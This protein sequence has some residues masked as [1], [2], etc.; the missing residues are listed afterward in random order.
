MNSPTYRP[1]HHVLDRMEEYVE[2]NAAGH[3]YMD[4]RKLLLDRMVKAVEQACWD[5][6]RGEITGE[7]GEILRK[8][9]DSFFY[10]LEAS[11]QQDTQET[12]CAC[13]K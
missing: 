11:H 2:R 5:E 13:A 7:E 4:Y 10:L 12:V 9:L 8:Q 3:T 1:N 6:V